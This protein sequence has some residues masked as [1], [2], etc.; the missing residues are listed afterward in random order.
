MSRRR[1]VLFFFLF[2]SLGAWLLLLILARLRE[3]G[4]RVDAPS[5]S[6]RFH[7]SLIE[8]GLYLGGAVAE[9]PPGTQAVLNLCDQADSYQC[10]VQLW[11]PIPDKAPAPSLDWLR[12]MVDFIDQ[13]QTA[14]RTTFV[15]CRYGQSRSVM[16]VAAYLMF[17]HRWT[18]DQALDFIRAKRPSAGPNDAFLDR[19]SEW[20]QLLRGR[21]SE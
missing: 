21:G 12:R 1:R 16:V 2:T 15:H 6:S 20:G 4:D 14:S 3:P 13:Q 5:D 19:L 10:E 8:D 9:P 11:E 7:F 18:R 17:K